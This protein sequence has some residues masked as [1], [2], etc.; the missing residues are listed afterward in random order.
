MQCNRS[1]LTVIFQTLDFR[2]CQRFAV[3]YS[4]VAMLNTPFNERVRHR[5]I[6]VKPLWA[7]HHCDQWLTWTHANS[8]PKRDAD[9]M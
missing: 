7:A 2:L 4:K 3:I 1:N 5:T 8:L 9:W 6:E